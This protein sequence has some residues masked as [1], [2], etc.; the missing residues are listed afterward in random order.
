M[1]RWRDGDTERRRDGDTCREIEWVEI[2][3]DKGTRGKVIIEN[4]MMLR[5]TDR[6]LER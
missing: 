3:R 5:S 4:R 2:Q 6:R 1:E